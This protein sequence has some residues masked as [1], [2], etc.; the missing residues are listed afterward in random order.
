MRQFVIQGFILGVSAPASRR[1]GI[2]RVGDSRNG[3][4]NKNQFR[5]GC[6]ENLNKGARPA[7]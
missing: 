2:A 5:T 7:L 3:A 4:L 6:F 1:R